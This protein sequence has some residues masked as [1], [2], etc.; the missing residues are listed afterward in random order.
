MQVSNFYLQMHTPVVKFLSLLTILPN[1]WVK[2]SWKQQNISNADKL[3]MLCSGQAGCRQLSGLSHFLSL[4]SRV[5][6]PKGDANGQDFVQVVMKKLICSL[7]GRKD[8]VPALGWQPSHQSFTCALP[9]F[10]PLYE[11]ILERFVMAALYP[12]AK[13]SI[14]YLAIGLTL[15]Q[16]EREYG[17]VLWLL[18]AGPTGWPLGHKS[19]E[20]CK[21]RHS[22][23]Q[24]KEMGWLFSSVDILFW[25]GLRLLCRSW[26]SSVYPFI[27]F[28][29]M[30]FYV[31]FSLINVSS[32]SA[33]WA[34][35]LLFPLD[36]LHLNAQQAAVKAGQDKEKKI[37]PVKWVGSCAEHCT[38][39][40]DS[41]LEL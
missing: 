6:T 22:L 34:S 41:E 29:S 7:V 16:K 24:Q 19:R 17:A 18:S 37:K 36:C 2:S 32:A 14:T 25:R 38:G 21:W 11:I 39:N 4:P 1:F 26:G 35:S 28:A 40:L 12:V 15:L 8:T 9:S 10:R 33:S 23:L 5:D 20:A 30:R 3:V 27:G 31:R 13:Y